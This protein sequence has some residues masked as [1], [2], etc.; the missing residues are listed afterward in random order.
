M[1]RLLF[2]SLLFF[3][4]HNIYAAAAMSSGSKIVPLLHA[5]SRGSRG[6]FASQLRAMGSSHP[7]DEVTLLEESIYGPPRRPTVQPGGL[8]PDVRVEVTDASYG[9]TDRM[10]IEPSYKRDEFGDVDWGAASTRDDRA[11]S[12][13]I[14][15]ELVLERIG[16]ESS[17]GVSRDS[18]RVMEAPSIITSM[19][20]Y[21]AEEYADLNK[22][23]KSLISEETYKEFQ[24]QLESLKKSGVQLYKITYRVDGQDVVGFV[25]L[26]KER[27]DG[28]KHPLV[29][30]LRGGYNG[31]GKF[32]EWGKIDLPWL[33]RNYAQHAQNGYAVLA[34]QYRN[35]EGNT[36]KD[37][38]GGADLHDI[39]ELFDIAEDIGSIDLSNISFDLFSRAAAMFGKV[40]ERLNVERPELFN[41][42]KAVIIKGGMVDAGMLAE[43]DPQFI[44][45]ILKD[46]RPD[47]DERKKEIFDELSLL[48]RTALL[49]NMSI[50]I[51]HNRWDP[52]IPVSLAKELMEKL[53]N[54]GISYESKIFE[55]DAS[56]HEIN[57][58]NDEVQQLKQDFLRRVAQ[59]K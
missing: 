51:L 26:P 54:L 10:G 38:F 42:I 30:G 50:L 19:Q 36:N 34:T 12:S 33:M 47:F 46:A 52:I 48:K 13:P 24:T 9:D 59:I 35:A 43:I 17:Y 23:Q 20:D 53:D 41:A 5:I 8:T 25:L 22:L 7:K 4:I 15:W 3:V 56:D 44:V 6:R 31:D 57:G 27:M 11:V 55:G 40:I 16:E 32:C 29:I 58:F 14:D 18:A 45:P 37:E 49:K 2:L 39:L 21:Q 28:K 1:K